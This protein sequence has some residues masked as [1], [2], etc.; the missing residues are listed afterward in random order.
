MSINLDKQKVPQ[1]ATHQHGL[2]TRVTGGVRSPITWKI[3]LAIVL[4]LVLRSSVLAQAPPAPADQSAPPAAAP[5]ASAPLP[6]LSP[7]DLFWK[8]GFFIWPLALC[9]VLSVAIII[10]RFVA[11]RKSKVIPPDFLPGLKKLYRDPR[12]DRE[13]ALRYCD[14]H[15]SPLAR[16][17][18]AGLRRMPRG[19]AAAEKAIEDAGGNETLKLRQNM[20]FLYS[21]GS[22]ATLLGLIGTIAGMIKA[23]QVASV[24]GPG[25]ADKLSEGIY[26]AMVNTFAG[27]AVAIVVTIFYYFFIGRIEKLVADMNDVVNEFGRDAGFDVSPTDEA[28]A[29]ATL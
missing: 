7:I 25:H 15:D 17:I 2:R 10:E 18:A 4:G 27:L 6:K 23:F 5:D 29:T 16:M 21:L 22:V 26:E 8:A 24:M 14:E 11:L 13:Q 28:A 12:D 20:R 3:T 19:Y 1:A 9:S